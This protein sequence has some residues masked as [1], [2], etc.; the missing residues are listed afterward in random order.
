M[1][2]NSKCFPYKLY[3]KCKDIAM[4][5]SAKICR[6]YGKTLLEKPKVIISQTVTWKVQKY[7]FPNK[8]MSSSITGENRTYAIECSRINKVK[9]MK[10]SL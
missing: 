5:E 4:R 3:V 10:D 7:S 2:H 8:Y 6:L 1:P 9:Y